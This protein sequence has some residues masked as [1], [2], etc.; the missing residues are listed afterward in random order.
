M[1]GKPIYRHKDLFHVTKMTFYLTAAY[2]VLKTM[3]SSLIYSHLKIHVLT[4]TQT[5]EKHNFQAEVSQ[6]L[7]LVI[8]SLYS[9]K[10][11]FL[12][13]L[14]SNASDACDKL[15]FEAIKNKKLNAEDL[16][17]KV[18]FDK[19][20]KTITIT[21]N[22]IGMSHDELI[23]NI[24][25]I[26]NSGTKK[27]LQSIAKKDQA[28]A[29]L[30]GQFGVGFYAS[31]IVAKEVEIRTL[32]AGEKSDQAYA[33][34]SDGKTGYTLEKIDKQNHGTEV[35]LHLQDDEVEFADNHRLRSLIKKYSEHVA[36][37][38]KM[39]EVIY[40]EK[41]ED[42]NDKPAKE[43]EYEVINDATALWKKNPTEIKDEDYQ[44]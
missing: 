22:G 40:P 10:D 23:E 12:R 38:I 18:D 6:V 13:E 3:K 11:I 9:N 2:R 20:A 4:M 43:P 41:D 25:T 7:D 31:F 26:A 32:K 30:I 44:A 39:L 17:I 16:H 5:A 8:H 19:D 24:G 33:W 1:A 14:I 15:R 28:D 21:D 36:F 29:N 35:I 37:P 27:Y 34:R 42:G